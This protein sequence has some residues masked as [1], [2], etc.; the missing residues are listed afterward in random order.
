MF[1]K[2]FFVSASARFSNTSQ[3]TV[4]R[5]FDRDP[6][7]HTGSSIRR[8]RCICPWSLKMQVILARR[9]LGALLPVLSPQLVLRT[10]SNTPFGAWLGH[11]GVSAA[12]SVDFR[13]GPEMAFPD[14]KGNP[15]RKGYSNL[16]SGLYMLLSR[17]FK[18]LA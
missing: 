1:L 6:I 10:S 3:K 9:K 8:P 15:E 18:F 7:G 12:I 4:W 17:K 11:S 5:L 13:H 2:D 16:R 14:R